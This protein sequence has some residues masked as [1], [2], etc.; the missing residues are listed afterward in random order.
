MQEAKRAFIVAKQDKIFQ[1]EDNLAN[2]D[3]TPF[4]LESFKIEYNS[5]ITFV[6]LGYLAHHH[7]LLLLML[8]EP[9]GKLPEM[10]YVHH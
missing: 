4:D 5:V 7:K 3:D 1:Y 9:Q 2:D 6:I 10:V 8:A